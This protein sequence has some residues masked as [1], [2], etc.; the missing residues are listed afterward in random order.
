MQN[1]KILSKVRNN[2][3]DFFFSLRLQ[4]GSAQHL[5]TLFLY[6]PQQMSH[7]YHLIPGL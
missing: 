2:V 7:L 5:L 4:D 1:L 3:A 6:V